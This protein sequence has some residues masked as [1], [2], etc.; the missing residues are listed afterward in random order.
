MDEEQFS[1]E[2]CIR[3][4]HVYKAIWDAAMGEELP[5]EREPAN[6]ADVCAV[7]VIKDGQC[8]GHIPQ[9]ISRVCSLFI[10]R[11]GTISCQVTGARQHSQ[12][13]PEGGLEVPC[14][15]KFKGPGKEIKKVVK[16]V[17]QQVPKE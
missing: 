8:V 16:L 6:L 10:R 5:C 3:G 15:M 9:K 13:L 11:G 14:L 17:T 7:A 2:W 1:I 12:D 4:Y